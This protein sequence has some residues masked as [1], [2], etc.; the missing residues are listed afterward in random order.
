MKNYYFTE[1]HELF[2]QGLKEFLQ[3]EVAPHIDEWEEQQR[4]PKEI[5]KKFGDMGYMGLNYPE[6]YGGQG[7]DF[8][9]S[10]VFCEEIAKMWSGGFAVTPSVIQYMSST[11]IYKHGSEFLKQ[12]YLVPTIKGEMVSSIGITEPGAGSDVANIKTK[13][14][15][16]GDFYIVNGSK[17][18]ITNAVYGDYIV[19]VVKTDPPK[20]FEGVSLLVIDRNAPGVSAK[21]LK[22]LGWHAS[23]TAELFFDNVKVPAENLVGEEGQGFIYLMGGL[24]LE[25]LCGAISAVAGCEAA[26]EYTLQ[27]MSER[28]AF[29]RSI[30]KFQVLRHRMAQLVAEVDTVKYYTYHCCRMHNE[31]EYAVK[32]SSIAK[33][34]ATELS[35]KTAYQCLQNFGGYGYMEEYKMARMFRDSRILTIGGGSTEIMREIIAKMV[36]DDKQYKKA[37]LTIDYT[38]SEETAEQ[39]NGSVNNS[40]NNKNGKTMAFETTLAALQTSA[41]TAPTLGKTLKF[42]FGESKIFIDGLG[43]TNAVTAEDKEADCTVSVALEDLE[44]MMAGTLN[45]MNAFMGGKIKVKGDMGVA[46][47]LQSLFKG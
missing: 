36:I 31:G 38:K 7:V 17:T 22:K 47:K 40:S 37:G 9:Y 19:T 15:R 29:G 26:I 18:F 4:I 35:D 30:N 24:Q 45:P 42:D 14:I 46:M 12:K 10:V 39:K 1:E 5:W 8:W 25:R 27:Y 11:Y 44:A 33:L 32:E 13:A 16:E 43:A 41:A 6:Q 28:Q 20:G 23:D 34:M 3:K 2:R 21:K